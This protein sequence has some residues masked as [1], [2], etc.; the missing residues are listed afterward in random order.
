MEAILLSTAHSPEKCLW[1]YFLS[2]NAITPI[3]SPMSATELYLS[4]QAGIAGN[5]VAYH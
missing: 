5:A 3:I 1:G 2:G 4:W